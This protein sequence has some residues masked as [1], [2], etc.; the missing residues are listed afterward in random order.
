MLGVTY[1]NLDCSY[2]D[3]LPCFNVNVTALIVLPPSHFRMFEVISF[4]YV[5]RSSTVIEL[6]GCLPFLIAISRLEV[7]DV[8]ITLQLSS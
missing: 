4:W 5:L 6:F 3:Y 1:D 8:I 2:Y 7:C